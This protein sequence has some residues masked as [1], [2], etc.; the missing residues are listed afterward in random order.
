MLVLRT[1]KKYHLPVDVLSQVFKYLKK[2]DLIEVS[3]VWKHWYL[4]IRS[5]AFFCSKIDETDQLF[6][7]KEWLLK[8]YYKHFERFNDSVYLDALTVICDEKTHI[9][10]KEILGRMFYSVLGHI[11]GSVGLN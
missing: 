4:L 8:S 6:N 2:V 7:N 1:K 10:E 3:A 11:F 9:I 5:N